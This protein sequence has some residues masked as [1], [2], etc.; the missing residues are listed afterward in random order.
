MRCLFVLYL[1]VFCFHLLRCQNIPHED[2]TH[3]DFPGIPTH[4]L[5]NT[6]GLS[7]PARPDRLELLSISGTVI[8]TLPIRYYPDRQ[9][10]NLWN[11]TEFIPPNE[12]FFLRVTGYDRDGFLFQRVSSVSFSNIVPGQW[13]ILLIIFRWIYK[14]FPTNLLINFPDFICFFI[15]PLDAPKVLMPAKTHGYYL[16]RGIIKC[17]VESFIPFTLRFSRDGGRLGVD[18]LFR[19]AA[20]VKII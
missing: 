1:L 19:W 14:R 4:I 12:A 2:T 8:K 16:Q 9:P 7:P 10:F 13:C 11:I 5:L 17:Q 3:I 18:Q 6:T 15:F 20:A